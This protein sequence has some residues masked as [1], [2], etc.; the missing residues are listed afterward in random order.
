[1]STF[2]SPYQ[3]GGLA[4]VTDNF[5]DDSMDASKWSLRQTNADTDV[6]N[7]LIAV[8]ETGSQLVMTSGGNHAS[9]CEGG[10]ISLTAEDFTGKQASVELVQHDLTFGLSSYLMLHLDTSNRLRLG[11]NNS[12]NFVA[13]E[14]IAGAAYVIRKTV[15]YN[16]TTHRFVRVREAGG[17]IVYEYSANGLAWTLYWIKANP[18][19]MTALKIFLHQTTGTAGVTAGKFSKFDNFILGASDG[20]IVITPANV[21]GGTFTALVYTKSAASAW[22]NSGYFSAESIVGDGYIEWIVTAVTANKLVGLST[23]DLD[24]NYTSIHYGFLMAGATY[25]IYESGVART[26]VGA[27]VA[28]VT[29]LKIERIGTT[30][31]YYVNGVSVRSVAGVT[32]SPLFVDTALNENAS[33]LGPILISQ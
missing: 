4:G 8:A 20:A 23:T 16:N 27:L 21:V 31:D 32:A 1:M 5:D 29:S 22:G 7:T 13:S 33:T 26:V 6:S 14:R 3:I 18:F 11:P 2:L 10:F 30:I 12:G 17:A 28:N 19:V 15:T 25:D 9:G 24:Q